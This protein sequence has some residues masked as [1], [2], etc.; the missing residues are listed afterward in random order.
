MKAREMREKT[1]EELEH[2]LD[3]WREEL[4]KLKVQAMSGQPEKLSQTQ[5]IRK[6]VARVLT[7]LGERNRTKEGTESVKRET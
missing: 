3:E 6:N 2:L 4:F 1:I 7:I 5:N